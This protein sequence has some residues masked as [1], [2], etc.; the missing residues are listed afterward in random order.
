MHPALP[1][2]AAR[3]TAIGGVIGIRGPVAGVTTTTGTFA[4]PGWPN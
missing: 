3:M 1:A 2:P 4:G